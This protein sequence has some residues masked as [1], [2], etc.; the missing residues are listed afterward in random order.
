MKR[1]FLILVLLSLNISIYSSECAIHAR[2]GV[3]L[4]NN[5]V[6]YDD[7]GNLTGFEIELFK[8][9]QYPHK[10]DILLYDN[11][12]DCLEGLRNKEID[13]VM[14]SLKTEEVEQ[15]FQYSSLMVRHLDIVLVTDKNDVSYQDYSVL[16][17]SIIGC[18]DIENVKDEA[19][20]KL[21][22]KIDNPTYKVYKNSNELKQA[23]R[24]GEIDFGVLGL[25]EIEDDFYIIDR[26]ISF[27][28]FYIIRKG[29]C[30]NCNNCVSKYYNNS[31][32]E[33]AE[34]FYK[35]YPR[36]N[37]SEFTKEETDYIKSNPKIELLAVNNNNILSNFDSN[38]FPD[39]ILIDIIEKINESS[40]L[41]IN[42]SIEADT[43]KV[44]KAIET[45]SSEMFMGFNNI[46]IK[47]NSQNYTLCESVLDIPMEFIVKSSTVLDKNK[48]HTIAVPKKDCN[49]D[50]FIKG[51]YSNWNIIYEPDL[52]KRYEL[53]SNSYVDCIIDS[54][55]NFNY[56]SSNW[57][58]NKLIRYPILLYNSQ[59][60][61]LVNSENYQLLNIVN[62]CLIEI[63]KDYIDDILQMNLSQISYEPTLL[64]FF[65][66]HQFEY[67][68]II[69]LV[70]IFFFIIYYISTNRKQNQLKKTNKDLE[71]A[72]REAT[73]AN[74]A[75]NI[76]LAKMCHDMRTPLGAVIALSDFGIKESEV[77][78]LTKYFSEINDSS[79]YLLSL[80]DDILDTQKLQQNDLEFNYNVIDIKQTINRILNIVE[81]RAKEKDISIEIQNS[82]S[83]NDHLL[84][85]DEKRLS[86]VFINLLN[87]AIK[88]T[89]NGGKI[90]WENK[91]ELVTE[92]IVYYQ[93]KITDTGVGISKEF[94]KTQ[95]F[96]P[97]SKEENS[98]SYKE[99]GSGLGLSICKK[100][101]D[102]MNGSIICESEVGVGTTFVL[103]FKFT[104]IEEKHRNSSEEDEIDDAVF[105]NKRILVCDDT[106]INI[107]IAKKILESKFMKVDTAINGEEAVKKAKLNDY[108]AVLMDIRMPKMDGLEATKL[109]REFKTQLPIIAY[110][111]NA[112]AKDREKS[113]KAGMVEH[114]A[115]PIDTNKL[116]RIL[117]NILK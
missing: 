89:Q 12:E 79:Q 22:V 84:V 66:L 106:E 60:K 7:N 56:I 110:S 69:I 21:N 63:K 82:I 97:F 108:D 71:K 55:Y 73:R 28:T 6:F 17:N 59:V 113:L 11:F 5:S 26:F 2:F 100:I 78:S 3:W 13:I 43:N 53:L 61:I 62:K 15:E 77:E 47:G 88:Y 103:S 4:D 65:M 8:A 72:E 35:Y 1:I 111:A 101:V 50:L 92:K 99:G 40:G 68:S 64:D 91:I 54:S 34:L 80:M 116:F 96:E 57:K 95:L 45:K 31:Y 112:Y 76:F 107:R 46:D 117:Y 42:I 41:N 81:N 24:S 32:K 67:I 58:Y 115:K 10:V 19:Q 75:K 29:D 87:N 102:Q 33:Y 93:S 51:N 30:F 27:P 94:I 109:I 9:I 105:V 104:S 20:H 23:L 52:A 18:V 37:I 49:Q 38:G 74:E 90:I 83:I 25:S 44:H 48:V 70:V 114:L 85:I 14:S 36:S 98:Q 86:Q 39:G 16:K